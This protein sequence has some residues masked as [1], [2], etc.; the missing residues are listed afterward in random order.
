ML[1]ISIPT[2]QHDFTYENVISGRLEELPYVSGIY[3][4]SQNLQTTNVY[5]SYS[6]LLLPFSG[7]GKE[8][9]RVQ[10]LF[11]DEKHIDAVGL[12][13]NYLFKS[14]DSLTKTLN[15]PLQDKTEIPNVVT[16]LKESKFIDERTSIQILD[17]LLMLD[18]LISQV[19]QGESLSKQD[20]VLLTGILNV[21]SKIGIIISKDVATPAYR[22]NWG[23]SNYYSILQASISS[24]M[25]SKYYYNTFS[26]S[27]NTLTQSSTTVSI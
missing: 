5:A 4:F 7:L 20:L 18:G 27:S 15:L 11:A 1:S 22:E 2:R 12:V 9:K 14:F 23:L 10:K 13:D 8:I 16:R 24:S 26:T 17:A 19:N 6:L 21:F 25:Y 3:G